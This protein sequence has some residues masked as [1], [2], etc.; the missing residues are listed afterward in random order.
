MA[1]HCGTCGLE[2]P[3]KDELVTIYEGKKFCICVIPVE[4]EKD[5]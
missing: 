4:G 3:D 5:D 1:K 2:N